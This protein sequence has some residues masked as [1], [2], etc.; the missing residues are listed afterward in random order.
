MDNDTQDE[1][2]LVVE[3]LRAIIKGNDHT[4]RN[5]VGITSMCELLVALIQAGVLR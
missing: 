5:Q 3:R 2:V 4:R 1:L